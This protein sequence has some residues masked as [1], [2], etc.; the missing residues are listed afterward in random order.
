MD[1]SVLTAHSNDGD[2]LTVGNLA[3]VPAADWPPSSPPAHGVPQVAH[4]FAYFTKVGGYASLNERQVGLAE[5]TCSAI[6]P[7]NSSRGILNIVALSALGLER[8]A[9]AR[10]AVQVMGKLAE[11]HGYHDAGESL[12]VA[13]PREAFIFHVLPDDSGASAVWVAQRVPDG[14]VAVVANSFTVRIV[15]FDDERSF[16]ASSNMRAV[17]LRTGRTREGSP[18]DFTRAFAAEEPGHKYASGRRMWAAFRR[19][20]AP[21]AAAALSPYYSEY[22][23]SGYP[24]TLPA[25]PASLDVRAVAGTMRDYY[26]NTSFDLSAGMAGGPFGSPARAR[27]AT[28]VRGNFERPIATDRTIVSYL[29]V[30]RSWLP[31]PLGGTLWFGHHS[32]LTT[33]RYALTLAP[34]RNRHTWPPF[35]AAIRC[36]HVQSPQVYSPFPVSFLIVAPPV[37]LPTA[38]TNNSFDRV[39]RGVS[40]WQVWHAGRCGSI[41]LRAA[42]ASPNSD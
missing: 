26:A 34:P 13:D 33:V 31:D 29:L 12:I 5:S 27:V 23:A 14:H 17:A 19:L 18:L 37:P 7:G 32:A 28:G 39:D 16:L 40:A 24:A 35:A 21:S 8:A 3:I 4:T 22:S 20:A 11:T 6:F 38:L 25:S 36:R 42:R 2:G 10:E 30:L 9:S 15:D 41:D 1:G